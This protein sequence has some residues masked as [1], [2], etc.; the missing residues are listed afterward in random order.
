M[1][2][3]IENNG[4]CWN[5][6]FFIN[7]VIFLNNEFNNFFENIPLIMSYERKLMEVLHQMKQMIFLYITPK[8]HKNG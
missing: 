8:V 1:Q 3:M 4:W 5:R 2:R 7:L 6:T